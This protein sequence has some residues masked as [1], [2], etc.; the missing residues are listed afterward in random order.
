M[1]NFP[2]SLEK[3][4]VKLTQLPGIGR[5]SAERIIFHILGSS[6]EDVVSLAQSMVCAKESIGLCKICHNLSEKDICKIC[7]DPTRLKDIICVVED[8]R[9]ILAIE[10]SGSYRGVYH[11]LM[12]VIS[13]LDGKG[14][15]DLKIKELI[16]RINS[17]KVKEI[18]IAT[19]ADTEGEATSIYLTQVIKP[20][21]VNV[22]RI[23]IGLP[24]GSDLDYAD[25]TTL[26]K[27]LE[28]RRQIH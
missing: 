11:I 4:L 3:L 2:D 21:G 16:T 17:D 6:K 7:D 13:P 12:G 18:I 25:P 10:K 19:D 5:R 20:L 23:G 24:S 1:A 27:A 9:D 22:S 14:P 15:D 28:S 8:A 26:S